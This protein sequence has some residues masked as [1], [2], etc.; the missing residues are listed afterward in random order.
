MLAVFVSKATSSFTKGEMDM[1][2]NL[3]VKVPHI[4]AA[5]AFDLPW[6]HR[7][8]HHAECMLKLGKCDYLLGKTMISFFYEPSTRTRAS[9]EIAMKSCGGDVI[10]STEN[11]EQFSSAAKGETLQDT[12]RVLCQYR[13]DVIVLR[14][15]KEGA[16]LEASQ[17]SSVPIINAGDGPGQH[18]TQALLDLFTIKKELGSI[19]GVSIAMVG[20][21]QKGRTVRSLCYL[22]GKYSS[23]KI[24]F[25][26]PDCARIKPD[27][28]D[29]LQ[30]HDV[31]FTESN[32]LRIV[33]PKV[34]VIYQ[35]RIQTERGTD[36]DLN[37]GRLGYFVVNAD[38][39]RL[40]CINA[41]VMHPLPRNSEILTEV[42]DDPRAV[43][44]KQAG[45]GLYC[46]MALLKMILTPS[47]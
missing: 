14:H 17:V 20:D 21:L 41:I 10:F 35:T 22:L 30:R 6:L 2:S 37:D 40:M 32:D 3:K 34:N 47:I 19:D 43:Y 15:K 31:Q 28:K 12:I 18:P 36:F 25:V 26:S 33:A 23:V 45:Y 11:A 46:R 39:L 13:P 16:A 8:F 38:I 29:Y 1:D 44:F 42:D 9:F 27:I 4:I 24:Y 7:F 5:Q